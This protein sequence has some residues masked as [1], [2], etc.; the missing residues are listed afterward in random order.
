MIRYTVVCFSS[1]RWN[2]PFQRTQHLMKRF[3]RQ[4]RVIY[5]EEPVAGANETPYCISHYLD[6]TDLVVVVPQ[7]PPSTGKLETTSILRELLAEFLIS[8]LVHNYVLWYDNEHPYSYTDH[9]HPLLTVWDVNRNSSKESESRTR[10]LKNTDMLFTN[11][12]TWYQ[13]NREKL[14][15]VFLFPDALDKAHIK[16]TGSIK[17]ENGLPKE[18]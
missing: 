9:L 15:A 6:Y 18:V 10:L 1:V 8:H 11:S 14:S 5:V 13:H 17:K 16:S 4:T 2:T 7:I 12:P 3:A